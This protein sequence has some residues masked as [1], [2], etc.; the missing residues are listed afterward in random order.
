MTLEARTFAGLGL[1]PSSSFSSS[2]PDHKGEIFDLPGRV[3]GVDEVQAHQGP[4]HHNTD[5]REDVERLRDDVVSDLTQHLG[6]YGQDEDLPHEV[7]QH[8]HGAEPRRPP[9]QG[10]YVRLLLGLGRE[11]FEGWGGGCYD[12]DCHH[13]VEE[14]VEGAEEGKGQEVRGREG[15]DIIGYAPVVVAGV[16]GGAI[17][18][19]ICFSLDKIWG[20]RGR[21]HH[22]ARRSSLLFSPS[23]PLPSYPSPLTYPIPVSLLIFSSHLYPVS[24]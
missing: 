17:V 20:G 15:H 12:D 19:G 23:V 22:K 8:V 21:D 7:H 6:A 4:R 18:P 24:I 9:V 13:D 2:S 16:R 5:D 14:D 3:Y 11:P 10:K 1:S